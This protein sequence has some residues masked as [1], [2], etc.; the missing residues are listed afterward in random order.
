M[1]VNIS[2]LT[3]EVKRYILISNNE[4]EIKETHYRLKEDQ[5]GEATSMQS[6]KH[7]DRNE[8]IRNIKLS[9]I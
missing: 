3:L 1:N 5:L 7:N 9:N 8:N 2:E 4:R 6:K